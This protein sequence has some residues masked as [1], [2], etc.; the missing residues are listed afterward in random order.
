[1]SDSE[2]NSSRGSHD[3]ESGYDVTEN[4][5]F[6][7]DVMPHI[8]T[9]ESRIQ[10]EKLDAIDEVIA[11]N[12]RAMV[13]AN[14]LVLNNKIGVEEYNKLIIICQTNIANF[15][16]S[17]MESEA[18][19]QALRRMKKQSIKLLEDAAK[20]VNA[21]N[22]NELFR[23]IEDVFKTDVV[24]YEKELKPFVSAIEHPTQ[25]YELYGTVGIDD[26]NN[27][28]QRDNAKYPAKTAFELFINAL[29][30]YQRGEKD[31]QYFI[32]DSDLRWVTKGQEKAVWPI[33]INKLDYKRYEFVEQ[34]S[35][36]L[37]TQKMLYDRLMIEKYTGDPGVP[38]FALSFALL[39]QDLKSK[40]MRVNIFDYL[41]N[42]DTVFLNKN[43][44]VE[45][46]ANWFLKEAEQSLRHS[47]LPEME[48]QLWH[49]RL[50]DYWSIQTNTEKVLLERIKQASYIL[51]YDMYTYDDRI[52]LIQQYIDPKID[53]LCI[54]YRDKSFR[55]FDH[56]VP[57]VPTFQL[58]DQTTVPINEI[59]EEQ[60]QQLDL[61]D[62][63]R[64]RQRLS[65]Y[66][67]D[68]RLSKMEIK[69]T[70]KTVKR[71][72]RHLAN[73]VKPGTINE[74]LFDKNEIK[75]DFDNMTFHELMRKYGLWQGNDPIFPDG[76]TYK[77]KI[78]GMDTSPEYQFK[79]SILSDRSF[80]IGYHFI[81]KKGH[82]CEML[83]TGEVRIGDQVEKFDPD[84][85]ND[86]GESS[87][88]SIDSVEEEQKAIAANATRKKVTYN[89]K[90]TVTGVKFLPAYVKKTSKKAEDRGLNLRQNLRD[91]F[92]KL[93]KEVLYESVKQL[94][95]QYGWNFN[96]DMP[97][98]RTEQTV[99][100]KFIQKLFNHAQP[101]QVLDNVPSSAKQFESTVQ[102]LKGQFVKK[103]LRKDQTLRRGMQI[104]YNPTDDRQYQRLYNQSIN[105]LLIISQLSKTLKNIQ[106]SRHLQEHT[107]LLSTYNELKS[108]LNDPIDTLDI[109]VENIT[110][111]PSEYAKE[112]IRM[113]D[114]K[115]YNK[116]P[117]NE[118][119][120]PALKL[121]EF[122]NTLREKANVNLKYTPL[123]NVGNVSTA[124]QINWYTHW[125]KSNSPFNVKLDQYGR[126]IRYSG[127]DK[128]VIQLYS[129]D[130][131]ME[132]PIDHV[133]QDDLF[134]NEPVP[135]LL[136]RLK[137]H[138]K[139]V[140][141]LF[142]QARTVHS[143]ILATQ[144]SNLAYTQLQNNA[145][146]DLTSALISTQPGTMCVLSPGATRELF[147]YIQ[148]GLKDD[149][150]RLQE[151][152]LYHSQTADEGLGIHIMN[153]EY[154]PE[155]EPLFKGSEAKLEHTREGLIETLDEEQENDETKLA[156]EI[157]DKVK[158]EYAILKYE[159][160]KEL[161]MV[162]NLPETK[163]FIRIVRFE[164]DEKVRTKGKFVHDETDIFIPRIATADELFNCVKF[165][166]KK[167]STF[168]E[169]FPDADVMR[170][171]GKH[172]PQIRMIQ[173]RK[174][175][176]RYKLT[177]HDY[178]T[179][180][181]KQEIITS[182][183][184]VYDFIMKYIQPL[185]RSELIDTM[186]Q[187]QSDK[188]G[189]FEQRFD[190][191]NMM[192]RKEVINHKLKFFTLD[193]QT[194][195]WFY[196][197]LN[198]FI[199]TEVTE[200][201]LIKFPEFIKQY[202]HNFVRP[203][204][205]DTSFEKP[206]GNTIQTWIDFFRN[207]M[208][209]P[210]VAKQYTENSG[211]VHVME[212]TVKDDPRTHVYKVAL[213]D[214]QVYYV[215][216]H[217]SNVLNR[218]WKIEVEGSPFP[219]LVTDFKDY[220][221]YVRQRKLDALW[222]YDTP[223][224]LPRKD[225]RNEIDMCTYYIG[226]NLVYPAINLQK[227]Y[228]H[229]ITRIMSQQTSITSNQVIKN[230]AN[231]LLDGLTEKADMVVLLNYMIRNKS[232]DIC[233]KYVSGEL[234]SQEIYANMKIEHTPD[235]HLL[236]AKKQDS[237]TYDEMIKQYKKTEIIDIQ[238]VRQF[239]PNS[240][241]IEAAGIL[242]D[243]IAN[244]LSVKN[245]VK[246]NDKI[247][248]TYTEAIMK[249]Y[250][251]TA[252]IAEQLSNCIKAFSIDQQEVKAFAKQMPFK[253]IIDE[254]NKTGRSI[255][256][257]FQQSMSSIQFI[258]M[259]TRFKRFQDIYYTLLESPILLRS[260]EEPIRKALKYIAKDIE[261]EIYSVTKTDK[262]YM[263]YMAIFDM[264]AVIEQLATRMKEAQ[265]DKKTISLDIRPFVQKLLTGENFE[266]VVE[267][268][269]KDAQELLKRQTR[270]R[271]VEGKRQRVLDI[272]HDTYYTYDE[273]T[274]QYTRHEI[275][276]HELTPAK[277][278]AQYLYEILRLNYD[279][280]TAR[281]AVLDPEELKRD[282]L[283]TSRAY[284][285]S[286][287]PKVYSDKEVLKSMDMRDRESLLKLNLDTIEIDVYQPMIE[288][289]RIPLNIL[290]QGISIVPNPVT[291]MYMINGKLPS[292]AY[293]YRYRDGHNRLNTKLLDIYQ[294]LG[295]DA[296]EFF[297]RM[298]NK[299]FPG[300]VKLE[301]SSTT[302]LY[303]ERE[304]PFETILMDIVYG[305]KRTMIW[306]VANKD[307]TINP[308][309]LDQFIQVF[310]TYNAKTFIVNIEA[311]AFIKQYKKNTLIFKQ[312]CTEKEQQAVRQNCM[313]QHLVN[314]PPGVDM[315]L[316]KD[317]DDIR[318]QLDLKKETAYNTFMDMEKQ[319]LHE[320]RE[321]NAKEIEL[322][323]VDMNHSALKQKYKKCFDDHADQNI[324]LRCIKDA[325]TVEIN[326]AFR[327][328]KKSKQYVDAYNEYV[329]SVKEIDAYKKSVEL[330][331][332]SK[333]VSILT[334][335]NGEQIIRRI[336]TVGMPSA[337][338]DRGGHPLFICPVAYDDDGIPIFPACAP[339][340]F[341]KALAGPDASGS[342]D[343]Y[344]LDYTA[345]DYRMAHQYVEQTFTRPNGFSFMVRIGF[346]PTIFSF[347]TSVWE[348]DPITFY[349]KTFVANEKKRIELDAMTW[350][351]A[352]DTRMK[353]IRQV[354]HMTGY[355]KLDID[356]Q[357]A[358]YQKML[359]FMTEP[360]M[361]RLGSDNF[362]TPGP[363][364]RSLNTQDRK[365]FKQQYEINFREEYDEHTK[366]YVT[367]SIQTQQELR[368]V[369]TKYQTLLE[370]YAK[371]LESIRTD[372]PIQQMYLNHY[373]W[374]KPMPKRDRPA[375]TNTERTRL[376][377]YL[378]KQSVYTAMEEFRTN[379]RNILL[380]GFTIQDIPKTKPIM[381]YKVDVWEWDPQPTIKD[382]DQIMIN[383]ETK[384]W[385]R[386]KQR[387][388]DKLINEAKQHGVNSP[389][390]LITYKQCMEKLE[391]MRVNLPSQVAKRSMVVAAGTTGGLRP[392]ITDLFSKEFNHW[393]YMVNHPFYLIERI[394]Y[395]KEFLNR[396]FITIPSVLMNILNDPKKH[397]IQYTRGKVV[398][399]P[400]IDELDEQ[401]TKS[402]GIRYEEKYT[403]DET[404]AEMVYNMSFYREPSF[405]DKKVKEYYE[406]PTSTISDADK[407]HPMIFILHH[408]YT[409]QI[410]PTMWNIL[411]EAVDLKQ[412]F[413]MTPIHVTMLDVVNYLGDSYMQYYPYDATIRSIDP[414]NVGQMRLIDE[415]E[416]KYYLAQNS[417]VF[418][419]A[420]IPSIKKPSEIMSFVVGQYL[421]D[422]DPLRL[423]INS[424][425]GARKRA[426]VYD[427][428]LERLHAKAGVRN[429]LTEDVQ[430]D[431][432]VTEDDIK[433]FARKGG[434]YFEEMEISDKE[435]DAFH[436]QRGTEQKIV[437]Y[438]EN[439]RKH[440]QDAYKD[441]LTN[442]VKSGGDMDEEDNLARRLRNDK[443]VGKYIQN[444]QYEQFKQRLFMKYGSGRKIPKNTQSEAIKEI[445]G[446]YWEL[447]FIDV[448]NQKIMNGNRKLFEEKTGLHVENQ[449]F[450][451]EKKVK[452]LM[453]VQNYVPATGEVRKTKRPVAPK[454]L[455]KLVEKAKNKVV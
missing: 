118:H 272:D 182:S 184:S 72:K 28:L 237:K 159:F 223:K 26:I 277:K 345:K 224:S 116:T 148:I 320:Y 117:V 6:G 99:Y 66:S 333:H 262:L 83:P 258:P 3:R 403:A 349:A 21:I 7:D 378:Q 212:V 420:N 255:I 354:T 449:Y 250:N 48:K 187:N 49:Q 192:L 394:Q 173:L 40:L 201:D 2:D 396:G 423:N 13:N 25:L 452:T 401:K 389:S 447:D 443:D 78:Y 30:Y 405:T 214:D 67:L 123:H 329:K 202:L 90:G 11:E 14:E 124:N 343:W 229:R 301:Y 119:F 147:R 206:T 392:M 270:Y 69:E 440:L 451:Q 47:T 101:V 431:A 407:T 313:Y 163:R 166:P 260:T 171:W 280:R 205:Y 74:R 231:E 286:D 257:L 279:M 360:N 330:P 365:E 353:M 155:D 162:W 84:A 417:T 45:Q 307:N 59:T 43:E 132:V 438:K 218:A 190:R 236:D 198:T 111:R 50:Q 256:E 115:T 46:R 265:R 310:E 245:D 312:G 350:K 426:F 243:L 160:K 154:D 424:T 105:D 306:T 9:E 227:L 153:C 358:R 324:I 122:V 370:K 150:Y 371:E 335:G 96:L 276:R 120:E 92:A 331:E 230:I 221:K 217:E 85:E 369:N 181:T 299:P 130:S 18:S 326:N 261:H 94:K 108:Q 254:H 197:R 288:M 356:K 55:A 86:A 89:K 146:H 242:T 176:D 191:F 234:T 136:A 52:K 283:I 357:L 419:Y 435:F 194:L 228:A 414:A 412:S 81:N 75:R 79:L 323:K 395:V 246:Y 291:N 39:F 433:S 109:M 266:R 233:A 429:K 24:K 364:Y 388:K 62:Q 36:Y 337:A 134:E 382:D 165:I 158:M 281:R 342:D 183:Q 19:R 27:W 199:H 338:G 309:I 336:F 32:E 450:K 238:F 398:A 220:V 374:A 269:N 139:S 170:Y 248:P 1:M 232:N 422:D 8:D 131:E 103:S 347:D 76:L 442:W 408:L 284:L 239:Y 432:S 102:G 275:T 287:D 135:V 410:R 251:T 87:D 156:K 366:Y 441:A 355:T 264:S 35:R 298:M 137:K 406:H 110:K 172:H 346:E 113:I 53:E 436:K 448:P 404:I 316:I 97:V 297:L 384:E 42:V 196:P 60:Y 209:V 302:T 222:T 98:S 319:F 235:I 44:T 390:Y 107:T 352:I 400:L 177:Y 12:R 295:Q 445:H 174:K 186:K 439:L 185:H 308:S 363:F 267:N 296:C 278:R 68:N 208:Y 454:N 409:K 386:I 393:L 168:E 169:C 31:Q 161:N 138:N 381:K 23:K 399:V 380:G 263:E 151:F 430:T 271:D 411:K 300:E 247:V 4:N 16:I 142:G 20:S 175:G 341:Y 292:K 203:I 149:E 129:A 249:K 71:I 418:I 334:L 41:T 293:A 100:E 93:P 376:Q 211:V 375:L 328:M 180:A 61:S 444:S 325:Q 15:N 207:T 453:D 416:H 311:D 88:T 314:V 361:R 253:F 193:G 104:I 167:P 421:H 64:Y 339:K 179:S 282:V 244:R 241:D 413:K 57:D 65:L 391:D 112:I 305:L 195:K 332:I 446:T 377:Y 315:R 204:V 63:K 51:R 58:S 385:R 318:F 82:R 80:K 289:E 200:T 415:E 240:S 56:P 434:R 428:N 285:E 372:L 143:P 368:D 141:N 437:K 91:I 210:Y 178:T 348:W 290:K 133:Y 126:F 344:K 455:A 34:A 37:D 140:Q 383:E 164:R 145:F 144:Y 351:E 379:K 397:F 128:A 29:H 95:D 17:K 321:K 327:Q 402:V 387:A 38:T 121:V 226:D 5:D 425:A 114:S 125:L 367:P 427:I 219:C 322:L 225:L 22:H 127:T 73:I 373:K 189:N 77:E 252:V 213:N 54:S 215:Y 274:G 70:R 340:Q 362:N 157:A 294:Q 303:S 188:F 106:R 317:L 152:L 10:D 33:Y 259:T 359:W 216:L 273:E 268:A 304:E